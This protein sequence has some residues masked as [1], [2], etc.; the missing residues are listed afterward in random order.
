MKMTM[1]ESKFIVEAKSHDSEWTSE[2][3]KILYKHYKEKEANTG[4]EIEFNAYNILREWHV[5]T[6]LDL[7]N[8]HSN[9]YDD[10]YSLDAFKSWMRNDFCRRPTHHYWLDSGDVLYTWF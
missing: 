2:E 5:T 3:L 10:V 1:T 4:I 7:W 6:P 9:G 8:S